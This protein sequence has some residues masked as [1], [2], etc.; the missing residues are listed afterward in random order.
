MLEAV[1]AASG[2]IRALQQHYMTVIE[3]RVEESP[4]EADRLRHRPGCARARGGAP[5]A[6]G[7]AGCALSLLR[8]GLSSCSVT[9]VPSTVIGYISASLLGERR[10]PPR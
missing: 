2:V 10:C 3:P 5:S 1:G 9:C 8:P 4:T 6:D 7:P